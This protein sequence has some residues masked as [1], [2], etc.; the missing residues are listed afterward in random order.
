MRWIFR[1]IPLSL[2]CLM[3]AAGCI[4]KHEM[5]DPVIDPIIDPVDG[6]ADKGTRFYHRVLAY[7]FTGTWCQYCPN[8]A[9]ALDSAKL[10][11]PGRIVEMAVHQ[12]DEMSSPVCDTIVEHFAIAGFP[13][14]VF[15]FDGATRIQR[16]EV[17]LL[18]SY[19]DQALLAHPAC[20]LSIDATTAGKV[21]LRIHAAEAGEYCLSAALVEDGIVARQTGYGDGYVNNSVLRA[22]LSST[23]KGEPLGVLE[24]G[25]EAVRIYDVPATGQYRVVAFVLQRL[26]DGS[27]LSVNAGQCK[28]GH[29]QPYRYEPD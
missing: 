15:D 10:L 22:T 1:D 21:T 14:V 18:T 17:G 12:Y 19:V 8:M 2:I 29:L 9:V 20:G 7:E 11:R 13:H 26:A 25:Q 16:Q 3:L 6:S 24:A 23:Y 5:E 28:I 27:W 4:G